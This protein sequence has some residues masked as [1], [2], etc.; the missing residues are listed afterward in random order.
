MN[1]QEPP[2]S[3]LRNPTAAVRG[4]GAGALV[5]EALVILLGILPLRVVG[6]RFSGVAIGILVALA[7]YCVVLAGLLRRAWAWWAGLV[8][9]VVLIV[10]GFVFHPSLTVLGVL[11]A[12]AWTY[13]LY[14]RRRVLG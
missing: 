9:P 13:V 11:Y 10:S 2:R 8:P 5:V 3:G 4:V 12:F 1:D 14:V 6:V 7:V